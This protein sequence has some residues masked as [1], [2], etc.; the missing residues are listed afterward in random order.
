MPHSLEFKREH[1]DGHADPLMETH[2]LDTGDDGP[3]QMISSGML[4]Y[5]RN[6]ERNLL[7]LIGELLARDARAAQEE[8]RRASEHSRHP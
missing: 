7:A 8:S 1:P 4:N 5:Y 3:L 2:R 6:C